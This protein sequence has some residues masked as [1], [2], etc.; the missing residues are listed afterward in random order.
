MSLGTQNKALVLLISE[1][2]VQLLSWQQRKLTELATLQFSPDD[3]ET[4][5]DLIKQYPD[6]P[7]IIVTDLIDENFRHDTIVHVG[8]SDREALLKRKLEFA[9][10]NTRYRIGTIIGR[11]SDGRKDDKILLS[12]INKPERIDVWAKLLLEQKMA[13]QSV[14]SIAHLLNAYIPLEKLDQEEHLLVTKLDSDNNLRQTF[15]SKGK[16]L[17][18]RLASLTTVPERRLGVE[19]LQESTQLRQYLERIQFITYEKPLKILLLASQPEA[20]LQIEAFSNDTNKYEVVDVTQRKHDFTVALAAGT[21]Q[22]VH[23]LIA[24]VL[25]KTTI[26]NVYAP[27]SL[28]KYS[29]LRS[30]AKA[31]LVTAAAIL[32]VG[33]GLNIPGAMTLLDRWQQTESFQNRTAPLRSEYETLKAS[34]PETPIPPREM[35]LVVSTHELLAAHAYSPMNELSLVAAALAESSGLLLTSIDWQLMEKPFATVIDEY[36]NTPEAPMPIPGL[37]GENAL[38]GFIL[39][40][41]TMVKVIINGEAYSPSSYRV[42]QD[43]VLAFMEALSANDGVTVNATKMPINVGIDSQV[44]ATINDSEVRSPFTLELD[45]DKY[46]AEPP[47]TA[48]AGQMAG[49]TL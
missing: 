6:F 38:T 42:A 25:E 19:I 10:R 11:Q 46:P 47:D 7:V 21:M 27:S 43:Q 2:S 36:G 30:F 29:D 33:L 34:F 22:P 17:F 15:I 45:I 28:T 48:D 49:A 12:A 18:S 31:L 3:L 37:D 40:E 35:Q 16:V 44:T 13:V 39:Q 41:R 4:F 5:V 1:S 24:R 23:Y 32:L 9:F 14:T 26:D 20:A 8:G